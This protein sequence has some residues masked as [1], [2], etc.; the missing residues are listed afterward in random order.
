[1]KK[2]IIILTALLCSAELLAQ[3]LSPC[4]G[5][6]NPASF[7]SGSQSGM[8]VGFYSGQTGNKATQA[9]NALTGATGVTLDPTV[10]NASQLATVTDNG[11]SSYCGSNLNP[12][13]Q[14]RIMS[15]TDGPGTG[16]QAGKDPSVNYALP[17]CPTSIDP[18][19]V[20]SIR[21]GNCQTSDHAE[22]L[23]YT[24][25][26]RI[27]NA[28]LFMYYAIVVQA[29]GHGADADPA[30]VIRVTKQNNGTGPW[31]QISDTLFYGISSN[32]LTNGVN[33]WHSYNGSGGNGF[34]RDWNKVAI[35]LMD[36]LY[37][38]V[39]VE[40]F[41]GDCDWSGHYAYCYIAGDCQAMDIK[42]SGCPAG[43]TS[44]VDTLRAPTGLDNYHWY[45][46]NVDGQ[47]IGSM[48][49][50]PAS[51]SWTSLANG[52]GDSIYHCRLSDFLVTQ[53]VTPGDPVNYF[54]NNMVFRCD[55]TSAMDPAKPFTSN[56][57]VRVD[58]TKP[59]VSVD[60]LKDCE[61]QITLTDRSYVP[62]VSNGC[63][64]TYTQ[65][66]FYSGSD[67]N[68]T[69]VESVTGGIASH[70]YDTIGLYAVK[71]RTF[72][73]DDHACFTDT[74]Y[75][76]RTLGR[77]KAR[78][79]LSAREVCEAEVVRLTDST[80]GS[81][82]RNWVLHGFLPN[83]NNDT[84]RGHYNSPNHYR[85][86]QRPFPNYKNP[87]ELIAFNGLYCRNP[88]VDTVF[89]TI[90]CS[91]NTFDTIEVFQHPELLV[92]GDTVVCNGQQT[93]ITV[94]TETEGCTYRW[95]RELNGTN[96]I[97]EGQTLRVLPYDDTCKYYVKVISRKQCVAWDSVNAYRVNPRL[98]IS[99]HDM[100][101]G[102]KV[103]LTAEAA[104]S[105]S[106]TAEPHDP[107]LDELLDENGHGPDSI[108]VSPAQTTTYTV[109][110]HGTNECN[111]NPL[112]ETINIHP[113]PVATV[114]YYPTFVDSDNPVVT[115]TDQSPYSVH[116][117]WYFNEGTP[118]EINS[119][120]S[121][122]FG[123]VSSDSVDVTMVA[124]NDLECSDT[125]EFRLPVTQFTFFAPN[126][127]TPE[128]PDNNTFQIFTA[129]A[130]EN[131]SIFIYDRAGRQVFSS[132][133]L[134]FRW[135]G[136]SQDGIKCPQGTY[137]YI[138]SYRRPGTEDIVTQKGTI[139]LLR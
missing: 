60:S 117:V 4:P 19:I 67:T 95:Y 34:Y 81:V 18:T 71:V 13:N 44:V 12:S 59:A 58:N 39:R 83:G 46:C 69:L 55:M 42:T 35:N 102:D 87:V 62:N 77:P 74:V 37:E 54:S 129:N 84:V 130:Q 125:I 16:S 103:T 1:M 122:N 15:N 49:N 31:N 36:Y 88:E 98:S 57:Y 38:Q 63:D 119:P 65:W 11:G 115:F 41:I 112:S 64:T 85:D 21:L 6:K 121:H 94:A 132:N 134:H 111:A 90:W 108:T 123:E 99:R 45:K 133:D 8:Y 109:V 128:R 20:K 138:I 3:V 32:G 26:V 113:I 114:D 73:R 61:S 127:F 100:C 76:V 53:G 75:K 2:I 82:R 25:N 30:F 107:Y 136:I 135:D 80:V 70:E 22:A 29:P 14:F 89:D 66:W 92:T 72:N 68:T 131:F 47:Y 40:M 24:M 139:T 43:A 120:C 86:I 28:L 79:D 33:G 104:Y 52:P 137:A 93:D 56:V 106:W 78:I 50:I 23:Y 10:Y 105:Y 91:D 5:L 7:T 126:I 101:E 48:A 97:A 9:P 96:Q 110:G 118:Q 116:R 124:Y 51:Y 17:Y 27:Q